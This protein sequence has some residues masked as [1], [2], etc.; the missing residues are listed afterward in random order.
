MSDFIPM[1][2]VEGS[3]IFIQDIDSV[4]QTSQLGDKYTILAAFDQR[5]SS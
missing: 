2:M 4:R 3:A 1:F 5:N